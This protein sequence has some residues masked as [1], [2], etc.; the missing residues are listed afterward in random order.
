MR[1]SFWFLL[2]TSCV[3]LIAPTNG[4]SEVITE[5]TEVIGII[6]LG[7]GLVQYFHKVFEEL[8]GDSCSFSIESSSELERELLQQSKILTQKM[9]DIEQGIASVQSSI[10]SLHRTLPTYVRYEIKFDRLEQIINKI[11][12]TYNTFEFYQENMSRMER[13]TLEDFA[14]S[15]TSHRSGS[16]RNQ[17]SSL[18]GLLVPQALSVSSGILETIAVEVKS[19]KHLCSMTQSPH[20]LLY[21]LYNIIALTEIKGYAMLQFSYMMLKIYNKGNFTAEADAARDNF[22][23]QAVE[24][25]KS[26]LMVLPNMPT[27]FNRCDPLEHKAG[28]TYLEITKLLQGYIENEVDMNDRNSCQ[29]ECGAFTITES[30]SCYKDMFCAKQPKCQGR[31]FDC[32]FFHADAWVCMSEREK[33]R[34]YDWVEYEDGTLLGNKGTCVNKI[35]VD[36]WW[37]WVFWHC[38]YCLCKCEEIS[39]DSDRYWSLVPAEADTANNMVVSGVRFIKKGRVIVP[40][41][42]QAKA[43]GEGGVDDSTRAWLEPAAFS[44]STKDL[45]DKNNTK[46]FMMSYEQRSMDMDTLE[47]PDGHVLTGIKLRNLGGHLN[48]EIQVTPI[49][50]TTGNLYAD[51]ST[52]IAND[53]TPATAKPRKLVPIIMPD[54]P[55]KYHGYSNV[56]T[57]NDQ[58]IQF[59]STSAYKDVSQTSIPFIDSQP[60][61][62]KPASWLGGAG[63]YHK[64]F[65]IFPIFN[66]QQYFSPGSCWLWRFRWSQSFDV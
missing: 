47:A 56:Q 35:K 1:S 7:L 20:Q 3:F 21:N 13:H 32:Q 27:E 58:Y 45:S 11:W 10:H 49:E 55:T 36:S 5:A 63:L 4:V 48:L 42:E 19:G 57:D 62:P 46:V 59:D 33:E 66:F 54:V 6:K 9:D 41:I 37:R 24:K 2:G 52:W 65:F 23:K 50:F 14:V 25:M 53:N 15:V 16:I 26:M 8:C 29:A 12:S 64:V 40:Q 30:K 43:L 60:V 28:L 31:I 61:A 18:H 34:R 39:D 22:E 44:N 17:L 38:S 51:R